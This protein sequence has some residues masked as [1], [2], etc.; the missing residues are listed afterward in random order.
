MILLKKYKLIIFVILFALAVFVRLDGFHQPLFDAYY[1]RQAH[2]ATVARNFYEDGI[3]LLRPRLDWFGLGPE[4]FLIQ[5]FPIY[6][7]IVAGLS[8]IFGFSTQLARLVS[9]ISGLVSGICLYF[10]VYLISNDKLKST[11]ALI[12]FWFFPLTIFVHHAVMSESFVL[13]LHLLSLLLWLLYLKSGKKWLIFITAPLTIIAIIGKITYGPFLLFFILLLGLILR[14]KKYYLRPE[15][16]LCFLV[17]ALGTIYWQ[18]TADSLNIKSGQAFYTSQN[19]VNL[20]WNMGYLSERFILSTWQMRFGEILGSITK[21]SALMSLIGVLV[22]LGY[23]HKEKYIFLGWILIMSIY[24]LV[25]FRMQNHIYY[26]HIVTPS[27]AVLAAYGLETSYKM[28][29]RLN[30]K[31]AYIFLM[32]FIIFYIYKSYQNSRGYFVLHRDVERKIGIMNRYLTKPGPMVLVFPSWDWHSVYTFYTGRKAS[33]IRYEGLGDLDT[34]RKK[35]YLYV[36]FQDFSPGQIDQNLLKKTK[37][38]LIHE[39][40]GILIAQF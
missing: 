40:K 8:Y 23:K 36:I 4:Q 3:N 27:V 24:Y 5:E 29:C 1:F 37:L 18:N 34:Y 20:V 9:I 13:L 16:M 17:I 39:D 15:I 10:L 33:I 32:V 21:I 7:A 38:N 25:F 19:P 35:G 12:F 28:I 22:L 30:K 14:G 11:L 2:T 31:I 26:F 6:Q